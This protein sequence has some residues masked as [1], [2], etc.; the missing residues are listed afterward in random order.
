MSRTVIK[1]KNKGKISSGIHRYC[2]HLME[3]SPLCLLQSIAKGWKAID[4]DT[5]EDSRKDGRSMDSL[6]PKTF[7]IFLFLSGDQSAHARHFKEREA[8]VVP[9]FIFYQRK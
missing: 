8:K 1:E 9:T 7:A 6:G 2:S 3:S 4:E 5:K